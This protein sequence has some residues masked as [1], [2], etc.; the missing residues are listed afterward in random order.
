MPAQSELP[1]GQNYLAID[2]D[3]KLQCFNCLLFNVIPPGTLVVDG[4]NTNRWWYFQV[5]DGESMRYLSTCQFTLIPLEQT[6]NE[7]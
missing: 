5:L 4:V 1:V 6:E 2:N 7:S 3:G